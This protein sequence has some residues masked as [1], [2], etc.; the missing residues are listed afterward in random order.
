MKKVLLSAFA[1]ITICATAQTYS[2]VD[3]YNNNVRIY[4]IPARTYISV[5]TQVVNSGYLYIVNQLGVEVLIM[6]IVSYETVANV[7]DLPTGKYV[8]Y[9]RTIKGNY[10]KSIAIIR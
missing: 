4:P 3:G 10:K 1:F 2:Y 6:K 5:K 8:L 7:S 9:M